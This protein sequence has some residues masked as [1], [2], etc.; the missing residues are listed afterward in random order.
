MV[1]PEDPGAGATPG[2][3]ATAA[4][5]KLLDALGAVDATFLEG[6]KAVDDEASVA[7]GYR[8]LATVLGVAFDVFLFADPARPRFVDINTPF[9][10]DR[11]WGGDNTDA[12]YAFAPIDPTRTY[13][14]R[15]DAGD[16]A[17]FSLTVYNEPAPG[18]WSDRIVAI[19]NDTDLDVGPDGAFELVLGP[20][21][22][23]DHTGTFVPLAEDAVAA[24]TRDYQVDPRT[25]RR[26]TWTIEA[27]DP[28]GPRGHTAAATA[29]SLRAV[30]RW[31]EEMFA[32]VPLTPAPAE[33]RTTE[34]HNSPVG[35]NA[36]AEPYEVG[37]AVYG[38]SARDACYAFGS[39]DLGPGDAL[40][41]RHRPPS[42]RFWN[43]NV[44]NPYM[45]CFDAEAVRT[46]VNVGTAVPE[47]DGTVTA[48]IAHDLLDHPN[49]IST[50]GHRRGVIAFRWF[51]AEAVPARPDVAVVPIDRL[52][53][54]PGP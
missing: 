41:V 53:P 25:G 26:V 15:G 10:P 20:R 6:P 18:Q 37:D 40:V 38:W 34:G 8:F 29:R 24:L 44:W 28:P 36:V 50:Q 48:V 47:A 52:P 30:R 3:E 21:R 33:D 19:V 12:W 9:R 22:P 13:R 1:A 54:P 2:D 32:I 49:A 46:S 43:L 17:Y 45:A 42:C 39:F 31:V 27:L 11:R 14:V 7:E 51:H 4:W 23:P 16:S 35:A 5:R